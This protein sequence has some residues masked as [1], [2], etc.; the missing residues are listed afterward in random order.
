MTKTEK[1]LATC[2]KVLEGIEDESVSASSALLQ[3]LK[4]A[5]LIND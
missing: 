4:I 5:R 1:A 3:C 2:E